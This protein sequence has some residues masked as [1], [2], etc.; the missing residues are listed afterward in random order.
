MCHRYVIDTPGLLHM[1][2]QFGSITEQTFHVEREQ[3]A[4][5][6]ERSKLPATAVMQILSPEL[7][8]GNARRACTRTH[9]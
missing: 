8:L 2:S 4:T 1:P 5:A 3:H 9:V 6:R 7:S